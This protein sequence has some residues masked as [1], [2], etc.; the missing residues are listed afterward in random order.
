MVQRKY[1]ASYCNHVTLIE[2]AAYHV[3]VRIITWLCV[4]LNLSL[5]K[6]VNIVLR[7]QPIDGW[8]IYFGRC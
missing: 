5:V 2:S 8:P 1:A 7:V 4:C 6:L 3:G